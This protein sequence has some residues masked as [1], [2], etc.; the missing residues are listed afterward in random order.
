M[1]PRILKQDQ[2]PQ[3]FA[4]EDAAAVAD[5]LSRYP[6]GFQR[7][8]IMPLL[9]LAQRQ[10]G[11][12]GANLD[13]PHGGWIS[14]AA[15][16]EIANIVGVAPIKVYEVATFYSMYNLAPVGKYH[17]QCC[18]TTPCW[19]RGSAKVV[20]ACEKHLG[21]KVGQSTPDGL[22]TLSEVECLGACV[23]APVVQV[24]DDY[25]EDLTAETTVELLRR[26]ENNIE[27]Q[28]GPQVR[29]F[30]SAPEGG[31]TVLKDQEPKSGK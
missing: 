27:P 19:L 15:M 17:V 7:S 16:D 1:K 11:A 2:Q 5:I 31:A 3:G 18:T 23:N 8:A 21:I 25:F 26:L 29:R 22:F 6:K 12:D 9:D 24:N 10:I 14:Q 28:V 20:D 4:F 30:N 13:K